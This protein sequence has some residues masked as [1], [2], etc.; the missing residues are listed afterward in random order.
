MR[1]AQH[2]ISDETIVVNL[3]RNK[4]MFGQQTVELPPVPGKKWLKL[5]NG[6]QEIVGHLFWKARGME[7]EYKQVL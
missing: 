3:D 5:C 7:M 1:L 2:H 4:V 6:L